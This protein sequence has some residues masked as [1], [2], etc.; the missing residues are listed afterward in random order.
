MRARCADK[1]DPVALPGPAAYSTAFRGLPGSAPAPGARETAPGV[2]SG[3]GFDPQQWG[4]G[5]W[6]L[7]HLSA[8]GYPENPTPEI[9]S[10]YI[11]FFRSLQYVLPCNGCRQGY[12]HLI[13]GP[14][15]LTPAVFA[16]R[17]SLFRWTVELHNAVN[18]KLNKE[19]YPDWFAWYRHYDRMRAG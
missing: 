17:L 10:Q 7:I 12:A 3:S 16:D 6:N 8:A 18:A 14:V 4:P 15:R 2:L 9:R 5:A 19:T 1:S 11:A 13:A